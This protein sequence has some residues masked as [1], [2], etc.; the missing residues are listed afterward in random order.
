VKVQSPDRHQTRIDGVLLLALVVYNDDRGFFKETFVRSRYAS[1]GIVDEF[2][3]DNFSFSKPSVL[4]GL[5]GD[6]RMSKLVQV[7]RGEAFDVVVDA[8]AASPTFGQW[9]GFTLNESNHYQIYV[10][11]GC[12]HGF[13]AISDVLLSYKQT[14]EYDPS[15]EVR[16]LWSD[17][18]LGIKW[19]SSR[20]PIV[21]DKDR[22]NPS[23][24]DVFRLPSPQ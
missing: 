15:S 11:A 24:R 2:V 10:P 16:V 19:P 20:E 9:E 18:D 21:S 5:H 13:L 12:L 7:L 1:L 14:S 3:Q 8:R 4:R 23:F 6:P 17:P 22:E